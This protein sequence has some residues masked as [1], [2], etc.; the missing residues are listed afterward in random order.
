[1]SGSVY[2]GTLITPRDAYLYISN[3]FDQ[4]TSI[5]HDFVALQITAAHGYFDEV[6]ASRITTKMTVTETL[7]VGNPDNAT[8]ITKSQLDALLLNM[9]QVPV[10][11]SIAP[12]LV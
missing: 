3:L 6:L 7:C 4:S 5:I 12:P 11:N 2:T 1:M 9:N 10:S 8:C